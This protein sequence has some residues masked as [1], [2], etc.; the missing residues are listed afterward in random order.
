MMLRL[1]STATAKATSF[2]WLPKRLD[3]RCLPEEEYFATK[4]SEVALPALVSEPP[5]KS[6][7]PR[8][9]PAT[10]MSPLESAA[11]PNGVAKPV[12]FVPVKL[13]AQRTWPGGGAP[14]K[15]ITVIDGDTAELPATS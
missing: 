5:P 1:V 15:T 4:I 12:W 2:P 7:V 14:F 13:F 10:M 9:C 8:N 11:K 6:T 3:Q